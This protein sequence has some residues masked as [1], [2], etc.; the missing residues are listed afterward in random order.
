VRFNLENPAISFSSPALVG[1]VA[2]YGSSDGFLNAVQ[3]PAGT[4][5]AR[6]QTDG[7][8]EN[9][10]RLLDAEGKFRGALMYPDNTLDG[11]M[12]GMR[13]MMTLGSVLS[14]PVVDGG[15]V[16]FGSTDGHLYAVR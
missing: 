13:T 5:L 3:L 6:F 15:V 4:L 14:S 10:P 12:I 8:R 1:N 16:Y 7:S 9:G 2:F 11:M